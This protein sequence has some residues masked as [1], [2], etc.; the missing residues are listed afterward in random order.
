MNSKIPHDR[1]AMDALEYLAS[2]IGITFELGK[3]AGGGKADPAVV[4]HRHLTERRRDGGKN[5][6]GRSKKELAALWRKAVTPT[7]LELR[8][9]FPG[10][11]ASKLADRVRIRLGDIVPGKTT[12]ARWVS[13]MNKKFRPPA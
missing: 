12:V 3:A 5:G 1:A 11:S 6:G 10:E 2:T 13:A 8:A 7:Y 4:A 9:K